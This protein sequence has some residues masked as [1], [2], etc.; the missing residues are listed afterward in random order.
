MKTSK[1]SESVLL[2]RY[3][4]A[5]C[6][7][8]FQALVDRYAGMVFAVARQR[9]PSRETAEEVAQ[10]VFLA[11]ARKAA[12]LRTDSSLAGWLHRVATLES[13]AMCRTERRRR[14]RHEKLAQMNE[15][16]RDDSHHEG[17]HA[18]ALPLL[19]EAVEKLRAADR[20]LLFRRFL[21]GL[22]FAEI[23]D[24][25]G[26]SEATGRKRLSRVLK[27]LSGIL[28]KQ[29]VTV[30][31]VALGLTMT[32]HWSRA[33]PLGLAQ[34]L[35]QAALTGAACSTTTK[36]T[37]LTAMTTTKMTTATMVALGAALPLTLQWA[38]SKRVWG[39]TLPL[40]RHAE[41]AAPSVAEDT[42][43]VNLPEAAP[44][45]DGLDLAALAR[46]LRRLP[47]PDGSLEREL[48]LELLMYRLTEEQ[49]L[50]VLPLVKDA[51]NASAL[52]RVVTA[53]FSRWA[54]Y[55]PEKAAT[56]ADGFGDLRYVAVGGALASWVRI[57]P[58][59][60]FAFFEKTSL[61]TSDPIELELSGRWLTSM[62]RVTG[63]PQGA[64]A[65]ME[66][67]ADV[68]AGKFMVNRIL[69]AWAKEDPDEAFAWAQS[70]EDYGVRNG[71]TRELLHNLAAPNP[72]K[73]FEL[74]MGI[75]HPRLREES[76]RWTL[77]Q[78]GGQGKAEARQAYLDLP[79]TVRTEH[80]TN[81]VVPFLARDAETAFALAEQLDAGFH[82]SALEFH[83]IRHLAREDPEAAAE[84]AL[85]IEDEETRNRAL[86]TVGRRWLERDAATGK[87]WIEQESGLPEETVKKLV[88]EK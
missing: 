61:T 37:F 86:T 27:K 23:G 3:V 88:S 41:Q 35:S 14:E 77:M 11:L 48:E 82:R 84:R 18:G 30:S 13:A 59:A 67:V 51:P 26:I 36:L 9:T 12:Q 47:L 32:S 39:P 15:M 5:G 80:L 46:E 78:W 28:S 4:E 68:D 73:A 20:E 33:A 79:E 25:Y 58:D 81:N 52:T 65:R 83:G 10:N 29:G 74:A 38:H 62:T 87:I 42:M 40:E 64:L 54:E 71:Y 16:N 70:K 49:I 21:E 45:P 55:D 1:D 63:D 57:H 60:A 53:L 56:V 19:D 7:A 6:E 75:D 72:S 8:S 34:N 43:P 2:R 44:R 66:A 69:K 17:A 85:G 22:S 31:S 76:V 24:R 50:R